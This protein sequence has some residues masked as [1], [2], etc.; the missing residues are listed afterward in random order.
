MAAL[1]ALALGLLAGVAPPAEAEESGGLT[2]ELRP[3]PSVFDFRS[4]P[5]M[6]YELRLRTGSSAER[7]S[8]LVEPPVFPDGGTPLV[9]LGMGQGLQLSGDGV[10]GLGYDIFSTAICNP[11]QTVPVHGAEVRRMGLD[12]ALPANATTVLSASFDVWRRHAPFPG[13]K[14]RPTFLVRNTLANGAPGTVGPPIVLRPPAPRITSPLGV[15][16]RWATRPRSPLVSAR[17]APVRRPGS[18]FLIRGRTTPVLSKQ[19]ITLRVLA[20]DRGKLRHVARVRTDRTGRFSY[21][22]RPRTT[23]LK[24]L[25]AV[26]R[27]Q[28]EGVTSDYTC[29]RFIR[30]ERKP[31]RLDL[32]KTV[33]DARRPGS[34]Q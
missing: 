21:R 20:G 24:Q 3:A 25:F 32:D 11:A 8:V 1:V 5:G 26:Y 30:I 34:V 33:A 16:I 9:P 31:P 4:T 18:L 14:V 12:V 29:P 23:G 2:A 28:Q 6:R 19:V 17:K 7:F 22:W 15:R 10:P 27:R 13:L